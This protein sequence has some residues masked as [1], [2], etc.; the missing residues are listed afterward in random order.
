L[1]IDRDRFYVDRLG[2]ILGAFQ[3]IIKER[4]AIAAQA[5]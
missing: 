2:Q 3:A 5:T 4:L 1:A